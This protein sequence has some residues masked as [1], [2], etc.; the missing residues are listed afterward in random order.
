MNRVLAEKENREILEYIEKNDTAFQKSPLAFWYKIEKQGEG[1]PIKKGSKVRVLYTLS[2]LDGTICYTPENEGDVIL[3][4]GRYDIIKGL[5]DAIL[6]LNEGGQGK[7]IIPS[8]LAFG[9]IG[10]QNCVGSK[11]TVIYDIQSVEIIP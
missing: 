1:S 4:I 2:L 9:M 6:M 11:R 7:F 5:D 8:D 3:N 10:D